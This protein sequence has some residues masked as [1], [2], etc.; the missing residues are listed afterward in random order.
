MARL[1][2]AWEDFTAR[3]QTWDHFWQD[4]AAVA[5]TGTG[6]VTAA[7]ALAAGVGTVTAPADTTFCDYDYADDTYDNAAD[8]YD[9]SAIPAAPTTGGGKPMRASAPLFVPIHGTIAAR[10]A[11]PTATASGYVV[12]DEGWLLGLPLTEDDLV[13]T[14]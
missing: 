14:R 2:A 11:A 10:I 12:D 3:G 5:I 13:L 8:T 1:N 7:A 4:A 9:C 6:A